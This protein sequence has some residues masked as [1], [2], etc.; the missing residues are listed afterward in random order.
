MTLYP[1][2]V[3]ADGRRVYKRGPSY[4]PLSPEERVNAVRKPDHPGA[5]RF[6]TRWFLPL[7]LLPLEDRRMP[8]TR[9]DD[10]TLEHRASCRCKVCRRPQAADVW[11]RRR[12][13]V[14]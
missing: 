11:R 1:V 13:T 2:K 12:H 14:R 9:P 7:V 6:H 5:V 8:E 3:E 4:M 10:Q